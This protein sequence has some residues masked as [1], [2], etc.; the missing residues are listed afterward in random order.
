MM[1]VRRSCTSFP[2]FHLRLIV[3]LLFFLIQPLQSVFNSGDAQATIY[4][5]NSSGSAADFDW[6]NGGS[7][8]GLFGDPCLVGGDTFQF[9]PTNFRAESVDGKS[10]IVSDRLQFDI[11]AHPGKTI[12]GIRI[13]EEG[14]YGILFEGKV[15][16]SGAMFVTNLSQFEVLKASFL[17]DPPMPISTPTPDG[18]DFW[19]GEVAVEGFEWTRL[20]VVMNNNLIA[21]SIPGSVTW[22]EKKSV[23]INIEIIVPEPATIAVLTLG[24]LALPL[25][26]R[27]NK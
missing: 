5:S 27:K 26:G 20:R 24:S 19:S 23:G 1:Q 9:S 25:F 17:M 7:D 13:T 22:I 8:K 2:R 18:L 6:Q 11:T 14:D 10:A 12:K 3:F 15:S 21:I 4:W 16:A